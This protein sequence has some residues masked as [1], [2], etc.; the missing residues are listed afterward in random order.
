A[1]GAAAMNVARWD[2][3]TW[4][5]LGAG[6]SGAVNAL[7]TLP[8]GDLLVGGFFETAGGAAAENIARWN[9]SEWFPVA[10][11]FDG[12]VSSLARSNDGQLFAGGS[13]EQAGG[14]AANRIARWDGGAW[15]PLQNGIGGFFRF[16]SP[17][18]NTIALLEDGSLLVGGHF[19]MAGQQ[20]SANIAHW[21]EPACAAELTCDDVLDVL[22]LLAYL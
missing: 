9:G 6:V 7:L 11:G 21:V 12:P 3:Q 5:S 22:D 10:G 2:G 15:E 17:R 18:V 20:P 13:F 14:V 4:S 16:G 1:D 19:T 8:D